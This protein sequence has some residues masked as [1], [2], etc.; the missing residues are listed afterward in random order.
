MTTLDT[1]RIRTP[2]GTLVLYARGDA[3]VGLEFGDHHARVS[4]LRAR[5]TRHL[6]AFETRGTRDPAGAAT[7]IT[8]YFAGDAHALDGQ[9]VEMFGTE[10]ERA[11]WEQLRRI[12][13]GTTIGYAA[14]AARVG[15]PN[16][17]RAVGRA[18][19]RNPVAL[20]VPC[21]R[22]IASD[23]TLGGYGGGLDRKRRLLEHEGALGAALV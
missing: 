15:R 5:L 22:V 21:H 23:G 13:A 2:I 1:A 8:A 3:L 20:V 14:L 19:G 18:N 11:V 12:P 10:F 9:K 17:S 16:G 4:D 6:G 7:R